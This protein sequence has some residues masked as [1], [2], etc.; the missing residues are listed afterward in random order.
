M[1]VF[2]ASAGAVVM[3]MAGSAAAV[4][5]N[6]DGLEGCNQYEICFNRDADNYRFQKHYYGGDSDHANNKFWDKVNNSLTGS[7]LEDNAY[8]VR[9]R[10]GSCYVRVTDWNGL[11]PSVHDDIP[12]NGNWIRLNDNV[13]NQNNEH[14]RCP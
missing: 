9:N 10:D 14:K 13:R 1:R 6:G 5:D 11:A 4:A 2:L 8:H 7:L 3:V 12:N